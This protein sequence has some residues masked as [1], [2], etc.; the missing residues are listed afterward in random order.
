MPSKK[1]HRM[2]ARQGQL[3][4]RSKRKPSS[5]QLSE[6][7]LRGP[8]EA[9]QGAGPSSAPE[10]GSPE[11]NATPNL[12]AAPAAT[13]PLSPRARRERQV[14]ALQSGPG[15]RTELLRIGIVLFVVM[16]MLIVIKLTTDL[17]G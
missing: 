13:A 9:G 10:S 12:S 15:I 3:S 16:A 14:V 2:A 1:G 11:R 4:H 6:A 8:T 17:G 7:Q 5:A